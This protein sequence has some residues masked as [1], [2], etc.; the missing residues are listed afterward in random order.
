[1]YFI[2]WLILLVLLL[3][4][5]IFMTWLFQIWFKLPIK[6]VKL[7]VPTAVAVLLTS[8][9]GVPF[10]IF[11]I[12]IRNQFKWGFVFLIISFLGAFSV[13]DLVYI[14]F[15]Q[16]RRSSV[17]GFFASPFNRIQLSG[18]ILGFNLAIYI[19]YTGLIL[20]FYGIKN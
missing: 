10:A 8:M 5:L 15:V 2:Q 3:L 16:F 7:I 4:E 11:E 20:I 1:M 12:V 19:L 13:K 9:I 6:T 14:K 17:R 18:F